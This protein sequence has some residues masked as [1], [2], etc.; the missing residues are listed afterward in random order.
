MLQAVQFEAGPAS[1]LL[2]VAHHAVIDGVSWRI[3][4]GDLA[5]AAARLE[6]GLDPDPAPTGT[7]MRRWAHGL[8][9]ATRRGTR[10]AELPFWISTL[11]GPDALLGA[12]ELDPAVD[13]GPPSTPSPSRF[14]PPRPPRC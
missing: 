2:L 10:A 9:E 7:S 4:L 6:H 5:A 11:S 8:V 3:L 13:V 14:P 12:R 1:R